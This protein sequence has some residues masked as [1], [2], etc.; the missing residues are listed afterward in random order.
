MTASLA[1]VADSDLTALVTIMRQRSVRAYLPERIPDSV[2]NA[3]FDLAILA[4]TSHN[5]ECWQ[6]TDAQDTTRLAALRHLCLN[7]PATAVIQYLCRS[8]VAGLIATVALVFPAWGQ[9]EPNIR[10]MKA[11]FAGLLPKHD[12]GS[13]Q[14]PGAML[15]VEA[16]A[17]GLIWTGAV[18]VSD[19][20]TGETLRPEQT[21]RIA[22]ITKSFIAAAILRLVEDHRLALDA[23]IGDHLRPESIALLQKG[24]YDPWRITIRLLLQHTSGLF[25]FATSETYLGRVSSDPLHRWTRMEQ[26][27]LAMESGHAYAEPGKVYK[28]SDTGY[29]LLG[30]VIEVTTGST[31]AAAVHDLLAFDRL[32]ID[33]TWFETLEP[34]RVGAPPRAHQYLE[35]RDA[36]AFDPSLDLFGGGGLVSTLEDVARF[37]RALHEGKIFQIKGTLDTMLEVTPQSLEADAEGYGLGIVRARLNGVVCYGHGGFWGILAWHCPELNVTV[38]AAATN[39]TG[40]HAVEAMVDGAIRICAAAI[41]APWQTP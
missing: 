3:C 38:V 18:G 14:L 28:Y 12:A 1:A 15:R 17:L 4:P 9:S 27:S 21:L 2:L 16:P 19:L 25:D 7:Q 34:V 20:A 36:N 29:I 23:R 41:A 40:R 11:D 22:S 24:G 33:N 5:L 10:Q 6:M 31:M 26:L 39:V 35:S 30:E 13:K 37:Y 32:G 8:M